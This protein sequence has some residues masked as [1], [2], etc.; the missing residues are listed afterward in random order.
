MYTVLYRIVSTNGI[1]SIAIAGNSNP[2]RPNPDPAIHIHSIYI[3]PT[4][5]HTVIR[6]IA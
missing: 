5:A 1:A 4:R 3:Y 6:T 2:H